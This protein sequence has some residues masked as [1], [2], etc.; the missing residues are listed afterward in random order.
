MAAA[1]CNNGAEFI[2]TARLKIKESDRGRVMCDLL[3]GFGVD[4]VY[5]DDRIEVK[6]CT[7]KTPKGPVDGCNDHRIVMTAATL[8]SITGGQISGAQAVRKSYPDYFD[9]IKKLGIEVETDGMD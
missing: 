7:L 4:T 1:A 2:G 8:L 5:E 3:A 9:V 6:K